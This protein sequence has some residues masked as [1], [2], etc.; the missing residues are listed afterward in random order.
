MTL[1]QLRAEGVLEVGRV[2]AAVYARTKIKLHVFHALEL[3]DRELDAYAV[4]L[5]VAWITDGAT[6]RDVSRDLG[7]G[8]ETLRRALAARGYERLT[9][10]QMDQRAKARGN[11]RGKLVLVV[12]T[13]GGV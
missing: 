5:A 7:V 11:R 13:N 4:R 9:K 6:S 2:G 10:P 8:Q 12:A 1:S 3:P